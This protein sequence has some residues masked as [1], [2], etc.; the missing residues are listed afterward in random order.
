MTW[1]RLLLKT[2]LH[3]GARHLG[4]WASF[5]LMVMIYVLFSS[6][7]HQPAVV[8]G[9]A[10]RIVIAVVEISQATLVVFSALFAFWVHAVQ[11]A[12][13]DQ[14]IRL[15]FTLGMTPRQMWCL[16]AGESLLL[17]LLAL[18]AGIAAGLLF[19]RLFLLSAASVF[20]LPYVPP[21][22]S[23]SAVWQTVIWFGLASEADAVWI[24]FRVVGRSH[25]RAN[26]MPPGPSGRSARGAWA[27]D[28]LAPVCL[29]GAY[30]L[31][32]NAHE[33]N[34]VLTTLLVVALVGVGTHLG[35]K[36]LLPDALQ[37][38]R[39]ASRNTV[40]RLS[41]VRMS[42]RTAADARTL[43]M[44]TLTLTTIFT[45]LGVACS[46]RAVA[47]VNT[48]RIAPF[49]IQFL[50]PNTSNSLLTPKEMEAVL[51]AKQLR[52]VQEI[53]VPVLSG[54]LRDISGGQRECLAVMAI[55]QSIFER[56]R[57][58]IALSYPQLLPY[59]PDWANPSAGTAHLL[60]PYP[61]MAQHRWATHEVVLTVGTT[62]IP[63][64]ITGQRN[65]R[66]FNKQNHMDAV[67]VL[68]D[69]TFAHG[70]SQARRQ[71]KWTIHGTILANWKHSGDAFRLFSHQLAENQRWLLTS[72]VEEYVGTMQLTT[73]ALFCGVV[74]SLVL[75]FTC[76]SALHVRLTAER[77]TVDLPLA[78]TLWSMGA[79]VRVMRRLLRVD[80]GR[81]F[82]TPFIV[83]AAHATVAMVDY[84]H[85]ATMTTTG[86]EAFFATLAVCGAGIAGAWILMTSRYLHYL[87]DAA[88]VD[89]LVSGSLTP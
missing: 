7:V 68:P 48:L 29:A 16:V 27:R 1:P 73:V 59:L 30:V 37:V 17:G 70:F 40:A 46:M 9:E 8:R 36:W 31:A 58:V 67:L 77:E 65:T 54:T 81:L 44:V 72:T 20:N 10:P 33:T 57:R 2:T 42:Q 78:K 52:I 43:T 76:L 25:R 64:K 32:L 83:A 45:A 4:Y 35:Y 88:H 53:H 79:D 49:S 47:E 51:T 82:L 56:V 84:S 14:E 61:Y 3:A 15:W 6:F 28:A 85:F 23:V 24:A 62:Q 71:D 12:N 80:T 87:L 21:P 66:L 34:V 60:Y 41:L 55:S 86:W 13:R 74:T 69:R 50:S 38:F 11:A 22:P 19:S 89:D 75:F 63:L 18:V 39:T 5:G 26:S